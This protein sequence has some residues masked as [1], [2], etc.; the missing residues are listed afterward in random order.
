MHYLAA[1]FT[2]DIEVSTKSTC[3]NTGDD[4]SYIALD[5]NG[6]LVAKTAPCTCC[7]GWICCILPSTCAAQPP[8]VDWKTT[9]VFERTMEETFGKTATED[10]FQKVADYEEM[11]RNGKVFGIKLFKRVVDRGRASR[12]KELF[13]VHTNLL[14]LDRRARFETIN[15][16]EIRAR[17]GSFVVN[18]HG[19]ELVLSNGSKTKLNKDNIV[20]EIRE[21]PFTRKVSVEHAE[22]VMQE[23]LIYITENLELHSVEYRVMMDI[24]LGFLKGKGYAYSVPQLEDIPEVVAREDVD[25]EE[26]RPQDMPPD[27]FSAFLRLVWGN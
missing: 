11:K 23:T 26:V 15:L 16:R 2:P 8:P 4:D 14:N 9:Q 20:L 1:L 17:R 6:G 27:R 3:C 22:E 5:G 13:T 12:T 18:P 10:A 21:M 25:V 24:A 19:L 7:T